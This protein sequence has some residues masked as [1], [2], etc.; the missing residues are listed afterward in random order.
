MPPTPEDRIETFID[1]IRDQPSVFLPENRI[2]LYQQIDKFPEAVESLSN[3]IS[4]WCLK[5]HDILIA[6]SDKLNKRFGSIPG[7]HMG[8]AESN[9]KPEPKDYK[10]LIKN[11]MR[12]SF[13]ETTPETTKEQKPPD[14]SK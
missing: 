5:Y 7:Q 3:A 2:D 4:D 12:E 6:L 8:P 14:S 11:Q 13:P 1:L 10:T 9:P